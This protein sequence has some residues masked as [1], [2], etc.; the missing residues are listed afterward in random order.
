MFSILREV[1]QNEGFRE[2]IS[3]FIRENGY[4]ERQTHGVRLALDEYW[5]DWWLF[6]QF[7]RYPHPAFFPRPH[8]PHGMSLGSQW[9]AIWSAMVYPKPSL[10]EFSADPPPRWGRYCRS[11][12]WPADA[13][14]IRIILSLRPGAATSEFSG[15]DR[16]T[17]AK[18]Y[19][20]ELEIRPLV[21][22]HSSRKPVTPLVGGISVGPG[23]GTRIE[24]GT[25]GGVLRRHSSSLAVTCAHVLDGQVGDEVWHPA[26]SDHGRA[27]RV[28]QIESIV[29]P[30]PR[31]SSV[32]NRTA[33]YAST[34]DV[35]AVLLD[36]G[37]DSDLSIRGLGPV[38][39]VRP[40]DLIGAYEDC[41]FAGKES[42]EV[43]ART[44]QLSHWQEISID[45]NP[46]CYQDLFTIGF[47]GHQYFSKKLSSRGD[48]GAWIV[49]DA[50]AG[51]RDLLGMLI[52]GDGEK[53]FCAFAENVFDAVG[54][55][56]D[57]IV[58]R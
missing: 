28:G 24:S 38:D 55:D 36:T 2:F 37:V 57:T 50:G 14:P 11:R 48:S 43:E 26:A 51:S 20:I 41:A 3:D 8:G 58:L 33:T 39:S 18:G 10:A 1:S 30:T 16:K 15:L 46:Y 29:S 5:L 22:G 42:D 47:R 25:L 54:I 17:W 35:A 53:S 52:G 34:T 19:P 32:C 49:T 44:E 31:R 4:L 6:D 13:Q 45:G 7:G 9:R 40:I 56:V 12:G 27:T 21:Q 23:G